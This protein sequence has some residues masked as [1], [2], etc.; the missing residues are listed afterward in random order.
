MG[1]FF[2]KKIEFEINVSDDEIKKYIEYK[3][4]E[5][6]KN[7]SNFLEIDEFFNFLNDIQYCLDSFVYNKN[8]E[9]VFYKF[10]TQNR[11]KISKEELIPLVNDIIQAI[12]DQKVYDS[13]KRF[14][15][16][17]QKPR[18][19][20]EKEIDDPELIEY[21]FKIFDK[22]KSGYLE[23]L[24][25]LQ[26]ISAF[27]LRYFFHRIQTKRESAILFDRYDKDKDDKISFEEFCVLF[28]DLLMARYD[29]GYIGFKNEKLKYNIPFFE[30]FLSNFWD[31]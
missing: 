30:Q 22:N 24:E 23:F 14:L 16:E 19:D 10:D 13:L 18:S 4:K 11:N 12:D 6:D 7:K 1:S 25:F 20:F 26:F 21:Y 15:N 17:E 28:K 2:T 8:D 9:E 3:F 31:N 27:G 29:I 5:H